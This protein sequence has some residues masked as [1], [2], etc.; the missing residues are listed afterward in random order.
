MRSPSGPNY[1]E[2]LNRVIEFVNKPEVAGFYIG[3]TGPDLRGRLHGYDHYYAGRR[4]GWTIAAGLDEK[5]ALDLEEYLCRAARDGKYRPTAFFSKYDEKGATRHFRNPGGLKTVSPLDKVHQVYLAWRDDSLPGGLSWRAEGN[6][7]F[8]QAIKTRDDGNEIVFIARNGAEF[9]RALANRDNFFLSMRIKLHF[10]TK[11]CRKGRP[12]NAI[13]FTKQGTKATSTSFVVSVGAA[14][15]SARL[16][17]RGPVAHLRLLQKTP[18]RL[19][20]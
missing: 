4:Q 1:E 3:M 2:C 10:H 12:K 15:P 16:G 14:T 11:D 9:Q 6:R 7:A 19:D 8:L 18:G 13:N 17:P 5:G 20:E